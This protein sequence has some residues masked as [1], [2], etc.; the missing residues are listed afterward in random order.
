MDSHW[1]IP[2][3]CYSGKELLTEFGALG[4]IGEL[5]LPALE[6]DIVEIGAGNSSIYMSF[7]AKKFNRRILYCDRDIDCFERLKPIPENLVEDYVLV[8]K[9]AMPDLSN[10]DLTHR[11]F[12]VGSSDDFFKDI[13]L[14]NVAFAFIDGDHRYAQV[15]KDFENLV[16]HMVPNGIICMHDTYPPVEHNLTDNY[17]SNSYLMRQELQKDPRFDCFTWVHTGSCKYGVTMVRV[18]E[19]DAPFYKQ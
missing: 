14:N 11:V 13:P 9:N 5:T 1:V 2:D 17:C 16:P 7:L 19:K 6:G 18:R 3:F 10:L 4:L 8:H 12:Y 15:K